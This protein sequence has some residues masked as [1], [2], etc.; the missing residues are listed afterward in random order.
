MRA[1][2]NHTLPLFVEHGW[3]TACQ[4][5]V[6]GMEVILLLI[7]LLIMNSGNL[8]SGSQVRKKWNHDQS[9]FCCDSLVRRAKPNQTL[10][11][12]VE[13][14]RKASSQSLIKR[15]VAILWFTNIGNSFSGFTGG[16]SQVEKLNHDQ[17]AFLCLSLTRRGKENHTLQA[18]VECGCKA[19]ARGWSKEWKSSCCSS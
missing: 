14:G 2:A 3:T 18:F 10:P 16:D 5:L 17:S 13:H 19:S 11:T 9:A 15:M 1:K 8:V 12:F 7:L 6:K 4:S